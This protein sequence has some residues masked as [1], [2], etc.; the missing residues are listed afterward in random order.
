VEEVKTALLRGEFKLNSAIVVI[1]FFVRHGVITAENE[2]DHVEIVCR[3]H[4]RL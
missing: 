3:L 1:D 4:R 2:R